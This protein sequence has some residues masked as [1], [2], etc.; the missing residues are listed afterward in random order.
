[1]S[2]VSDKSQLLPCW[3]CSLFVST[4]SCSSSATPQT[5][6]A[7]QKLQHVIN[8][9]KCDMTCMYALCTYHQSQSLIQILTLM[10]YLSDIWYSHCI[11]KS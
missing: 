8:I 2:L 9:P 10:C 4:C 7:H 6:A 11:L 3:L 5:Q 1:M